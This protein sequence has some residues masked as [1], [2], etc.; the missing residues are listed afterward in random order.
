[1]SFMRLILFIPGDLSYTRPDRRDNRDRRNRRFGRPV[2]HE[3]HVLEALKALNAL[4][5]GDLS[6]HPGGQRDNHLTGVLSALHDAD[7]ALRSFRWSWALWSWTLL[8]A[9]LLS[10]TF[11][12]SLWHDYHLLSKLVISIAR[13]RLLGC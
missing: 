12:P 8:G 9:G 10:P 4:S 11:A 2:I 1:M 3:G 5:S 7:T 13:S 6:R